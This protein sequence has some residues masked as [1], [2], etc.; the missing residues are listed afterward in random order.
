MRKI[1]AAADAAMVSEHASY[2]NPDY[3][4]IR[5]VIIS[6]YLGCAIEFYDFL[7]YTT[8]A[9]LVFG[10]VFFGNLPP[11]MG[12]IAAYTTFAAGYVARDFQR[13]R[14][15]Q[16]NTRRYEGFR[17]FPPLGVVEID[18]EKA[19]GIVRH[20]GIDPNRMSA[21]KMV[22]DDLVRQRYQEL[23]TAVRTFDA[24]FLADT[25]SPFIGTRWR[26]TRLG[27]LTLPSDRVLVDAT[28][29][30]AAEQDDL[31]IRVQARRLRLRHN[32]LHG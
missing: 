9:A 27:C 23:V 14:H 30:Q 22:V 31:L 20:Q 10:H 16:F 28:L 6:G 13:G 5:R 24:G 19:T 11:L 7:V 15:T 2:S 8:A 18:G 3:R 4:E 1:S 29:K 17:V 25:W 21:G 32:Y 26:V 12:T